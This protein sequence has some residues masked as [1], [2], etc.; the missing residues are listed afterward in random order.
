MHDEE[1]KRL[2]YLCERIQKE[3]APKAFDELVMELSELLEP[4]QQRTDTAPA[5]AR[6]VMKN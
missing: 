2:G 3:Q 4:E 5:N 6:R 1:R